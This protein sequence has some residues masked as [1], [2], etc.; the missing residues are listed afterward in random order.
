MLLLSV[1]DW[2]S[3]SIT[4]SS[5]RLEGSFAHSGRLMEGSHRLSYPTSTRLLIFSAENHPPVIDLPDV[6]LRN[7]LWESY[8]VGKVWGVFFLILITFS[9]NKP[10]IL[11]LKPEIVIF[12]KISPWIDC[13]SSDPAFASLSEEHLL[14]ELSYICY[15]GLQTMA[16]ELTR[17]SS[18]RT[19]AILKKWI[20]TRNSR[21]T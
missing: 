3:S 10:F 9:K 19:A 15:L 5:T 12:F 17:I 8:V 13:D 18:P 1:H 21:F 16:I 2:E 11:K 6:Q 7:D 4:L 14:K 20:W